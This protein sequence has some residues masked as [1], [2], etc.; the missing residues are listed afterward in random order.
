VFL[1]RNAEYLQEY[2][3]HNIHEKFH[4]YRLKILKYLRMA[5]EKKVET[6]DM[7]LKLD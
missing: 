4:S 3:K 7:I 6:I 1:A 5:Y 2:N